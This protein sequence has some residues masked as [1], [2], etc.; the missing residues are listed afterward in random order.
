MNI[1]VLNRHFSTSLIA[2]SLYLLLLSLLCSLGFWQ[3][4]RAKQK[5]VFLQQQ[6]IGSQISRLNLNSNNE[7]AQLVRYRI[8]DVSGHY[9]EQHSFL[10]DNQI[11]DGKPGYSVLTPFLID[12]R[13]E[14]ILVNRGWL[15][16]AADR[17]Q[18]PDLNLTDSVASVQ[19]RINQ[20][21]SVGIK[22]TGAEIPAAGWPALI[23]LVDAGVLA[24][25][26]GYPLM[27]VQIELDPQQPNGYLRHWTTQATIPPE[28]HQAYA[29]QWFG[30]ALTLTGLFIWISTKKT[31]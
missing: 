5:Q 24:K 31:S 19:G 16:V 3:L 4:D 15:P 10:L 13:L 27:T 1:T 12:G 17:R 2:L 20:F 21:P 25:H 29:V 23:Q 30:L 9:D 7:P 22:L 6:Q 11:V 28:K 14:A 8:A 26:L 18:L